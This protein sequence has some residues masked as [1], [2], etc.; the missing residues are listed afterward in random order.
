MIIIGNLNQIVHSPRF[1]KEPMEPGIEPL[2]ALFARF[3]F[4]ARVN[5]SH[6][7]QGD[8]FALVFT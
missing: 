4:S 5:K 2:K 6:M 3:S 8:E 1:V 7:E